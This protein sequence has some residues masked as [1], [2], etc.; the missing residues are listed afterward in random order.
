MLKRGHANILIQLQSLKLFQIANPFPRLVQRYNE[1]TSLL[2]AG[3]I[4]RECACPFIWD[5]VEIIIFRKFLFDGVSTCDFTLEH[6]NVPG[7]RYSKLRQLP[8]ELAQWSRKLLSRHHWYPWRAC[9]PVREGSSCL[10]GDTSTSSVAIS[11]HA[12]A[13]THHSKQIRHKRQIWIQL[14]YLLYSMSCRNGV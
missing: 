13:E 5:R 2:F 7:I 4:S 8:R 1:S 10:A 9:P 3:V 11:R 12:D 14:E 6:W